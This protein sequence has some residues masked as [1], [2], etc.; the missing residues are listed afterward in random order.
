ML[1]R[2]HRIPLGPFDHRLL[3]NVEKDR[4]FFAGMFSLK[5][6]EQ[7][8]MQREVRGIRSVH[9]IFHRCDGGI[10]VARGMFHERAQRFGAED[11]FQEAHR[12]FGVTKRFSDDF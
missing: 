9:G 8:R 3:H 10:E 6:G 11:F 12:H 7:P 1:C 4:V 5:V 2:T